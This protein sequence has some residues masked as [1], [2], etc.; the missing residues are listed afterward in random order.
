MSEI[1]LEEADYQIR[2]Y[3]NVAQA[4]RELALH[5]AELAEEE[6]RLANYWTAER[7]KF[8]GNA[9]LENVVALPVQ[10]EPEGAA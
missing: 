3:S 6:Q 5:F 9:G 2:R 10:S 1:T 7:D 4:H 8:L